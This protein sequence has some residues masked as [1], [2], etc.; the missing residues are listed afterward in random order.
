MEPAPIH[1]QPSQLLDPSY[2]EKHNQAK[3]YHRTKDSHQNSSKGGKEQH[4]ESSNGRLGRDTAE[5][6]FVYEVIAAPPDA[7]PSPNINILRATP[8]I[9]VPEH[10]PSVSQP[11][12]SIP[13]Q[14]VH[15]GNDKHG[16]NPRITIEPE[17]AQ[18]KVSEIG[19]EIQG[20]HSQGYQENNYQEQAFLGKFHQGANISVNLPPTPEQRRLLEKGGIR[21]AQSV[22]EDRQS[23]QKGVQFDLDQ[24]G[25]PLRQYVQPA[26][27]PEYISS[28]AL[29]PPLLVPPPALPSTS[30]PPRPVFETMFKKDG[31]LSYQN[32][33]DLSNISPDIHDVRANERSR[34]HR[35]LSRR[36]D[37]HSHNGHSYHGGEDHKHPIGSHQTYSSKN[38]QLVRWP[39]EDTTT[40]WIDAVQ[41]SKLETIEAEKAV[42]ESTLAVPDK[43]NMYRRAPEFESPTGHKSLTR[44]DRLKN[45]EPND[46]FFVS[47]LLCE[48]P[49]MPTQDVDILVLQI[50]LQLLVSKCDD[51]KLFKELNATYYKSRGWWR[52]LALKG[53][54]RIEFASVSS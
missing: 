19:N 43:G 42:L 6:P 34:H 53:V 16:T 31:T 47:M 14:H 11:N 3:R 18:E 8:S 2:N 1:R 24:Y 5:T 51:Y 22:M 44:H 13:E 39:T 48:V 4:R 25:S 26:S 41:N 29:L 52:R 50:R 54:Q 30:S 9:S 33:R 35:S 15:V 21:R 12:P 28:A 7:P 27:Y 46:T 37:H 45:V 17:K 23:S 32:K 36:H 20:H 40:P 10:S 49:G 38:N